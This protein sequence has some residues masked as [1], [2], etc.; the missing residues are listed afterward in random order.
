[1]SNQ[2]QNTLRKA[3]RL[4]GKAADKLFVGSKSGFTHPYRFVWKVRDAA[5]GDKAA[6]SVLFAV[7]KR[8]IRHAVDRNLLKRRAREAYRQGKHTFVA[9]ATEAGKHIDIALIY[10]IKTISDYKTVRDGVENALAKIS[11]NL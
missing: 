8:N 9:K 10:S 1:M 2:P 11:R 7:P 3:E 5:E 4:S 6:V